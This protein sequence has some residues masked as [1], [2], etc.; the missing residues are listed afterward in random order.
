MWRA[1]CVSLCC[2]VTRRG[3]FS[4]L[5]LSMPAIFAGGTPHVGT[6]T[7]TFWHALTDNSSPSRAPTEP[8]V[9][10]TCAVCG[11]LPR[12][13]VHAIACDGRFVRHHCFLRSVASLYSRPR[14]RPQHSAN[15]DKALKKGGE[16]RVRAQQHGTNGCSP[17]GHH[18]SGKFVQSKRPG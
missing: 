2:G 1:L 7:T 17:R 12:P 13:C 4:R 18:S 11:G 9:C 8:F 16:E 5:P 14:F 3:R 10:L 6:R 15:L